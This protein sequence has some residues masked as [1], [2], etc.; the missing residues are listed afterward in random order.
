MSDRYSRGRRSR[1]I[2]SSVSVRAIAFTLTE[3]LVVIAIIA[4]LA[5]LLLP[6]LSGAR[7]QAHAITCKSNLRQ[8]AQW[9]M[10]YAQEWNDILPHNGCLNSSPGYYME[11]STEYWYK[12]CPYYKS[13]AHGGTIMHCP[14]A[15]AMVQ[16]RWC[17]YSRCDFDY[18]LNKRL[19]GRK[20]APGPVVP[21]TR[22][23]TSQKVWFGE[24]FFEP[25]GSNG[26]YPFE[27][28]GS[29]WLPWMWK[30]SDPALFGKGH[31][32]NSANFVFGDGHTQGLQ[33]Q[34]VM[35][36]SGAAYNTFWG[37][38]AD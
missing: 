30:T 22:F 23:L 2:Y 14:R 8:I 25:N 4:V 21:K 9:G 26:Y 31:S 11:L 7:Q 33:R 3:L 36:L 28:F 17:Y 18:G 27:Y 34:E 13:R 37:T 24:G 12:K 6:A 32:G 10:D 35:P 29:D 16:P 1:R 5:A 15:T 20:D 38:S 19:G